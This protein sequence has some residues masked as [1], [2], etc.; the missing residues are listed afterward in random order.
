MPAGGAVRFRLVANEGEFLRWNDDR[1]TSAWTDREKLTSSVSPY[2]SK[3]I[4]PQRGQLVLD[5]GCGGGG[6]SLSMAEEVGPSGLVAGVDISA[7]LL[8]LARKR[9]NT[10]GLSNLQF[11]H[12]DMQSDDIEGRPFDLA[13]SQFGV[14]FFDEP[15]VAFGNIR[16]HLRRGGRFVFAAWQALEMNP[17]HIG[18]A[19]RSVVPP[20]PLTRPGKS[21]PGPFTLGEVGHATSILL[22]AGFTDVF[23]TAIEISVIGPASTIVD[24]SLLDFMG[25]PQESL[26]RAS[27]LIERHLDRL[28]VG[29][30]E[31]KFPLAFNV[32]EATNTQEN[33]K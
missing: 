12:S 4:A 23:H 17:W 14:M 25:V 1:W 29:A 32:F 33:A 13:V 9:S 21:A 7:P 6:I 18:T 2:L 30:D 26:K 19:L 31:Y 24:R 22:D 20:P 10:L 3:V 15:V 28:R 5:V 11:H 8:E 27:D 16:R